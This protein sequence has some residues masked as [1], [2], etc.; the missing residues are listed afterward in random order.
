MHDFTSHIQCVGDI[1]L[2]VERLRD[3]ATERSNSNAMIAEAKPKEKNG[4]RKEVPKPNRSGNEGASK[5][6]RL[7]VL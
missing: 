6:R 5:K 3:L 2:K 7:S 4:K 1:E